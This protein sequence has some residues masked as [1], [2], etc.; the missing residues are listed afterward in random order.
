MKERPS[1]SRTAA[2]FALIVVGVV[3]ALG[4]DRWVQGIDDARAEHEYLTLVL[5]D[6]EANAVIFEGTVRDWETA[7]EAASALKGALSQHVRPSDSGLWMAVARAGTVNTV[8]ARDA[9]FRDLEATGN[10]RLISDRKLRAQI[11][12]YFTQDIRFGRP[13]IEDRLDLRF[14]TF[15]RERVP[16]DLGSHRELCP[17]GTPPFDCQVAD[18]PRADALWQSLNGDAALLRVLNVAHADAISAAG[19]ARVWLER[20]DRLRSRLHEV[21]DGQGRDAV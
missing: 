12:A 10:V 7:G 8:P 2:E 20:T 1:L 19:V 4:V 9:S 15:S 5:A 6:V 11:V 17:A 3:A 18:A 13:I 16:A 21:L 14:R